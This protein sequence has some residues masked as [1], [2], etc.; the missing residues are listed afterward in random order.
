MQKSL[1]KPPIRF[2]FLSAL[3]QADFQMKLFMPSSKLSF[4]GQEIE[5][6]FTIVL[7]FSDVVF[8]RWLALLN[9]LILF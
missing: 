1:I 9:Y 6:N 8:S 3:I 2:V 5:E 7:K 4:D